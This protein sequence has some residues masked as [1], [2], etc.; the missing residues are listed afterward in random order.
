MEKRQVPRGTLP[1]GKLKE[2]GSEAG[3]S[4]QEN[5]PS[6]HPEPVEGGLLDFHY[7]VDVLI[8]SAAVDQD[9]K[10]WP[11]LMVGHQTISSS[12]LPPLSPLLTPFRFGRIFAPFEVFPEMGV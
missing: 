6:C 12:I 4:L 10:W 8:R 11:T 7:K 3:P 2:A 9:D 5:N 1:Y